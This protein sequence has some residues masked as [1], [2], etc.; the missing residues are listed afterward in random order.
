MRSA[1]MIAPVAAEEA[2]CQATGVGSDV[3]RGV[4]TVEWIANLLVGKA[5]AEFGAEFRE[6]QHVAGIV[7]E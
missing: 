1:V 5:S 6:P 4:T 2:A 7:I 3:Q